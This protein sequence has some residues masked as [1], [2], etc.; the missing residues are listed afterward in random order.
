MVDM[1][2]VNRP[3]RIGTQTIE[4]PA[5]HLLPYYQQQHRL[6]DR[7]PPFL[8]SICPK[9]HWIID[10]GAN[11][12]DTTAAMIQN[13]EGHVLAIEGHPPF[14]ELLKKNIH[15]FPL[16]MQ[17]RI[18]ITK[19]LVG[20]QTATGDLVASNGTAK[21]VQGY[22]SEMRSLDSILETEHIAP[23]SVAV[24]KTDTDGS[25]SDV[26]L[27]ASRLLTEGSAVL[28]FENQFE[29]DLQL[30][31]FESMYAAIGEF[32]YTLFSVFDN[33]GNLLLDIAPPYFLSS[34]N[35]YLKVQNTKSATRT[36]YY[37]DVLAYKPTQA[38]V[39]AVL[40]SRYR[41]FI[42]NS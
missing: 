31:Q 15:S 10:V 41:A 27:S 12:G 40:T 36:V 25:D 28:Y 8:A 13:T 17:D 35:R 3:Y 9:D 34:L 32:G 38:E 6:Y 18:H 30:E 4:L 1:N 29:N 20:T 7:F 23:Q 33:F 37:Y 11:V 42:M 24:L 21:I 26:L 14:F 22:N 5:G 39:A 16:E 2:E 19:A